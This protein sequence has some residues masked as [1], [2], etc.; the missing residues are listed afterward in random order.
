MLST[1]CLRFEPITPADPDCLHH[2]LI[3]PDVRR[4]LCDDAV[5]SREQVEALM[6]QAAACWPRGLGLWSLLAA[7]GA[8]IGIIGL[9]PVS[10]AAAA[11][12]PNA[13]G[14]LEPLAALLPQAWGRGYAAQA[15]S[16]VAAYASED[17]EEGRLVVLVDEP[18]A[19]SL[20]FSNGPA[21]RLKAWGAAQGTF[22]GP[23]HSPCRNAASTARA[24]AAKT[25]HR[26]T[27]SGPKGPSASEFEN[28]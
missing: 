26:H 23:I 8:W 4:Y 27:F 9:K 28:P 18:N 7:D 22:C 12:Y 1:G 14:R 21:S 10:H 24:Q 13:A 17:L 20:G 6:Q 25:G 16:Q 11:A 15:L 19:C 5:L 2:L 3:E